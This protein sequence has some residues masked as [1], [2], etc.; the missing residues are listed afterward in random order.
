MYLM[1]DVPDAL[2][3]DEGQPSR[4]WS[5]KDAITYKEWLTAS[6]DRRTTAMLEFFG[7][8]QTWSDSTEMLRQLGSVVLETL[9]SDEFSTS[10][11]A[12]SAALTN[13]GFAL[14][15][16]MGLLLAKCLVRDASGRVRWEVLRSPK[17]DL[18]YNLPVLKG[19]GR[20]HLDPVGGSIAAS[21]SC[22][23]GKQSS[24]TWKEIYSYWFDR[25]E[26]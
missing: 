15:A 3:R 8:P 21:R 18:A 25:I 26:D 17:S 11:R 10:D 16:D 9:R 23:R 5:R 20:L 13:A 12:G 1:W 7:F 2:C 22:L 14:A 6:V 4:S 19:F 24:E